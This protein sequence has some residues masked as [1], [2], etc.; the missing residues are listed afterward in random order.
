MKYLFICWRWLYRAWFL[1]RVVKY[2]GLG[3][4][5]SFW[6]AVTWAADTLF[7]EGKE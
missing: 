1:W 7:W 2:D 6:D 3:N 5:I 4:K